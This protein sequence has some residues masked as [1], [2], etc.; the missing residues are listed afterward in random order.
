[1]ESLEEVASQLGIPKEF[2][3]CFGLYVIRQEKH[4]KNIEIVRKFQSYESPYI[5][6]KSHPG[7]NLK[8]VLRKSSWDPKIDEELIKN[9]TC[10]NMLYIQTLSD[11]EHGWLQANVD[12]RKQLA[13]MQARGAKLEYMEMARTQKDYGYQHFSTCICDYPTTNSK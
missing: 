10:L 12:V 13:G 11:V 2:V 4:G 8:L 9:K 5:S 7:D 1:M 3:Y 6:L